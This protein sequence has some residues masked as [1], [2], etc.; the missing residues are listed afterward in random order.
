[1]TQQQPQQPQLQKPIETNY[2][3]II[4]MV[5]LFIFYWLVFAV[6]LERYDGTT[7]ANLWWSR[8]STTPA[9]N[10][11]VYLFEIFSPRV[12]RHLIPVFIGMWLAYDAAIGAIKI[13]YE[14]QDRND[15]KQY[16]RRL[17]APRN[18][19]ETVDISYNTLEP[20]RNNSVLL[21]LGGPGQIKI[22]VN[23]A[24]ITEMNGRYHRILSAGKHILQPYEYVHMVL[25]L[26]AQERR[27]ENVPLRSRD[28]ITLTANFNIKYRL[29]RGSED[30]TKERPFP[31]DLPSIHKAAYILTVFDNQT[32][33]NWTGR[34]LTV[35][36]SQIQASVAQYRLDEILHPTSTGSEPFTTLHKEIFDK[37]KATLSRDG[38][39]L[40]ELIL[41]K[42][43]LPPEIQEQYI[44]SWQAQW[45]ARANLHR[46][47]GQAAYIE[48]IEVAQAEAEVAMMQAILEGIQRARRSGATTRTSE[49]VALRLVESLEKMA[50]QSQR[51]PRPLQSQLTA[52]HQE[53]SNDLGPN[54]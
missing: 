49:I 2:L 11:V 51:A 29:Q 52:L 1:M 3:F 26:R 20:Q 18:V 15:A 25:D 35:V 45:Q 17:R 41:E 50:A 47:E 32:T 14:F 6:F 21:R 27:E 43:A 8:I 48:E 30:P 38:I 34:P 44:Q 33:S 5:A 28:N 10:F 9:P 13:L 54:T 46:A 53:I 39:E 31:V 7:T 37:A 24:A 4:G 40:Q 42:I 23:E 19:V 22:S 12:L 36:R 16:L